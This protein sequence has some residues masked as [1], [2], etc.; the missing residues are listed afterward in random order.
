MA[1]VFSASRFEIHEDEWLNR[2]RKEVSAGGKSRA[3]E[4]VLCLR[5]AQRRVLPRYLNIRFPS[6]LNAIAAAARE[7]RCLGR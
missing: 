6:K 7:F 2:V 3:G 1:L 4:R 5:V